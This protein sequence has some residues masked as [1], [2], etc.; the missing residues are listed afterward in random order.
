[1]P[2]ME[3]A[4]DVP[5]QCP[6]P[7]GGNGEAQAEGRA[8]AAVPEEGV[9]GGTAEEEAEAVGEVTSGKALEQMLQACEQ[10]MLAT[11]EA[12]SDLRGVGLMTGKRKRG[13][14]LAHQPVRHSLWEQGSLEAH[15][16]LL[17]GNLDGDGGTA[18]EE[19]LKS[20]SWFTM[21]IIYHGATSHMGI[22]VPV[23]NHGRKTMW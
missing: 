2:G 9:A 21:W 8:E 22:H 3:G 17:F 19:H 15:N 6:A 18:T 5:N 16:E 4:G 20:T 1:M 23:V 7:A 13:D 11:D 12:M 14:E 10:D